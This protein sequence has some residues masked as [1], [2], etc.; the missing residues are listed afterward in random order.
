[1]RIL[2]AEYATPKIY[3][4]YGIELVVFKG[5]GKPMCVLSICLSIEEAAH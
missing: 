4:E 2:P 3:R 1:M 5:K